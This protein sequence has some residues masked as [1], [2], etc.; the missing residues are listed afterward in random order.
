MSELTN[1]HARA[2]KDL[3]TPTELP[4]DH[5]ALEQV[6]LVAGNFPVEYAGN[7]AL[8]VKQ[9]KDLTTSD[10]ESKKAN[11]TDVEVALSNLSTTANKY[12]PTLSE[13]NSHLATMSVNDVVTIGEEANKGLWYKATAGATI[14]TRVAYDPLTQANNYT[15]N[16]AITTK[17]EAITA[18]NNYTNL[19]F[20][21]VPEVIAPYVAQAETAATVATIGADVFDTPEAG[22]DP[23]TGVDEGAYFNVRSANDWS[24]ID[25]YQNVGGVATPSGKS[26][27]SSAYVQDIVNYTVM[28]FSETK[29]YPIN[30]RVMLVN[31]DIV[32]STVANNIINPNVD[33]TG[34]VK[35]NDA[36]QIFDESGRSQHEINH[37][38]VNVKN[39]GAIGDGTLHTLQEWVDNGKFSNL[40]AIQMVYEFATAL[41]NSIDYVAIAQAIKDAS[42]KK[43]SGIVSTIIESGATVVVPDGKYM[44]DGINQAMH[45]VCDFESKAADFVVPASY[46]GEVIRVGEDRANYYSYNMNVSLPNVYKPTGSNFTGTG[47]TGVRIA[48]LNSSTVKF[49]RINYFETLLDIGGVGAGNAYNKFYL[50]MLTYGKKLLSIVPRTGG[51]ANDNKFFGGTLQIQSLSG[52]RLVGY[53]QLHI[54][55]T[56]ST[57]ADNEFYGLSLEGAGADDLIYMKNA[58][59]NKIYGHHESGQGLVPKTFTYSGDT[60]THVGH[61]LQVGDMITVYQ[62]DGLAMPTGMHI[63]TNYYVVAVSG[64]TFKIARNQSGAAE[65]FGGSATNMRYMLQQRCRFVGGNT[66]DNVLIDLFT[67]LSASLQIIQEGGAAGNGYRKT[68]TYFAER[69]CPANQPL[70]RG[71]NTN[72]GATLKPIFAAYENNVD[73]D[74]NPDYWR[75]AI[76]PRGVQ[77]GDGA[78]NV[79]SEITTNASFGFLQYVNRKKSAL[80][81][82]Q[83]QT[84]VFGWAANVTGTIPANS[85]LTINVSKAGLNGID[86][87]I[88]NPVGSLPAG[89]MLAWCRVG[90]TDTAQVHLYNMTAA[91]VNV[92]QNFRFSHIINIT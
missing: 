64:D 84:G 27:P 91:P 52:S 72:L 63:F 20:D 55:G 37:D 46:N 71:K 15:N 10:L 30:A 59:G 80:P 48:N 17:T 81:T 53:Y 90:A 4:V 9:I 14:L 77:F 18:A 68:N 86:T 8:T 83:I 31:G 50:N 43:K 3:T 62:A 82:L 33:M 56:A 74:K 34:W 67:P 39:F 65:S 49:G 32:K 75:T 76:S 92:N 61:V 78:G 69:D 60:L 88:A 22:V 26:Y 7:E 54:D 25:E 23:M 29:V 36:S 2:V 35:T 89:V 70:F 44:L 13:A 85:G 87:L 5:D 12:Y 1:I 45:I 41:T 24:Y 40:T 66:I 28:P 16:K 19:V 58:I 57:V 47:S 11:K 73:F 6:K 21:A 42:S 38:V 79:S 51:W